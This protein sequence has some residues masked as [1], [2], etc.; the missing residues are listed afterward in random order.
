[1]AG[2]KD[3]ALK[4][5][6]VLIRWAQTSWDRTHYYSDLTK[7]IGLK[8]NQIGKMMG[9]VQSILNKYFKS[10]GSD[11]NITL[12][13]LVVNKGTSLPSDGFDFVVHNY[14]KLSPDSKR[15]EVMKLNKAA[16]EYKHWDDMLNALNLKPARIFTDEEIHHL[17]TGFFGSGGEGEEHKSIKEFIVSHP[18][19]VNKN[20]KVIQSST[21][22]LLPSGDRLDVFFVLKDDRHVAIEVKPSTSS[23]DDVT[24]GI[25]RCIKYK[26]VMDAARALDNGQYDTET[27][28]I[29]AGSMSD[30]NRLPANDLHVHYIE[31]FKMESPET[32][33]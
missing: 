16:H 1:M 12:N 8:T 3:W 10:I 22:E 18:S 20:W 28:L 31:Q 24:R 19:T 9:E 26:A 21:E 6:P 14:S 4:M 17:K 23:D 11:K 15:G 13:A 30:A 33:K 2:T 7:D 32:N 5:I 27:M 29:I 25:F